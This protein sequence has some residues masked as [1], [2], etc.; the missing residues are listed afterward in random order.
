MMAE[1]FPRSAFT[2]I[3]YHEAVLEARRQRAAEA[4]VGDRVN[5]QVAGGGNFRGTAFR[6]GHPASTACT[7]WATRRA[8]ARVLQALPDDGTWMLVEPR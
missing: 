5:F 6:P 3:D 8:S 4:G 7:T 2:G 1:A